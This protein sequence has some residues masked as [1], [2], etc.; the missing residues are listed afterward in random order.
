MKAEDESFWTECLG[1]FTSY[2]YN[3]RGEKFVWFSNNTHD[4]GAVK[5]P[6]YHLFPFMRNEIV[7]NRE[8]YVDWHVAYE[9]GI[10]FIQLNPQ[11][12]T[13]SGPVTLQIIAEKW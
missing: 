3:F 9:R 4:R 7:D 6:W 13:G 8:V 1:C 11:F 5:Y 10:D 12:Y 2:T